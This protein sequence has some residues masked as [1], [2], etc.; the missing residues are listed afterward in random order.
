LWREG[1]TGPPPV[2]TPEGRKLLESRARLLLERLKAFETPRPGKIMDQ[3]TANLFES[4]LNEF[5]QLSHA[6]H[7]STSVENFPDDPKLV[8]LG[9]DVVISSG[10]G[11]VERCLVVHPLEASAKAGRIS[12]ETPLG[13]ALIGRSV[14]DRVEFEGRVITIL[15]ASRRVLRQ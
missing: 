15:E 9:D 7:S 6:I 13:S 5:V 10:V 1:G 12:S 8:Q 3:E 2:L 11:R 4:T 14:G